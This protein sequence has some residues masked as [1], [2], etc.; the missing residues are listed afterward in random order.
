MK[1]YCSSKT[2]LREQKSK[3]Q[4]GRMYLQYMYQTTDIY[5]EYT[6]THTHTHTSNIHIE[7]WGGER[8]GSWEKRLGITCGKSKKSPWGSGANPCHLQWK[9]QHPLKNIYRYYNTKK[10]IRKNLITQLTKGQRT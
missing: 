4:R 5:Q 2:L 7:E 9:I 8:W 10:S 6:H 1:N 3:P